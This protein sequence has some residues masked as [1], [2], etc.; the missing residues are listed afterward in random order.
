MV[1]PQLRVC[2][3]ALLCSLP[4]WVHAEIYKWTDENGQINYSQQPPADRP[5]EEIKTPPPP[6]IAPEAAQQEIETLI[7]NQE[8]AEAEEA[9]EQAA[10]E[11]QA[12]AEALRQENCETARSNYQQYLNNPGRRV[13]NADGEVTRPTEEERQEKI[14]DYQNKIDEF[15]D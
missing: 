3:L 4:F 2:C 1:I 5:A 10:Q 14:S 11:Q 7:E 13:M 12:A 6:P 9:A 8:A 15:C